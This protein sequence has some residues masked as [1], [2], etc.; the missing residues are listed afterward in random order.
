MIRKQ[1]DLS[2]ICGS[3]LWDVR[4]LMNSVNE[5]SDEDFVKNYFD[6]S[7]DVLGIIMHDSYN[8]KAQLISFIDENCLMNGTPKGISNLRS[9]ITSDGF[10][11]IHSDLFKE[12]LVYP[13]FGKKDIP[14]SITKEI[15][16]SIVVALNKVPVLGERLLIDVLEQK[17]SYISLDGGKSSF[18]ENAKLRTGIA[19]CLSKA[20]KS[21]SIL[22]CS[23][24]FLGIKDFK[25]RKEF[26]V[27]PR[28]LCASSFYVDI[29]R[30]NFLEDYYA[31]TGLS[32]ANTIFSGGRH[33]HLFV[34]DTEEIRNKT[35]EYVRAFNTWL[36]K[37]YG[38]EMYVSY[39]FS[40]AGPLDIKSISKE[41]NENRYRNYYSEI[42]SQRQIME[43]SKYSAKDIISLKYTYSEEGR[44]YTK[45]KNESISNLLL[46]DYD[47]NKLLKVFEHPV[48]RSVEIGPRRYLSF[49]NVFDSAPIRCYWRKNGGSPQNVLEQESVG[50]LCGIWYG[51][52]PAALSEDQN[53]AFEG[54]DSAILRLD[55]DNFRSEMFGDSEEDELNMSFAR[56]MEQ[57][58][59]LGLFLRK[60]IYVL[61]DQFV[62]SARDES[63]SKW[64]WII[65]EGADDAFVA[66]DYNSVLRFSELL[67]CHYYRYSGNKMSFSGGICRYDPH[68]DSFA[69][70]AA[71]AQHLMD[72]A[73]NAA[74]KN[75]V[76]IEDTEHCVKW[77]RIA[78]DVQNLKNCF[79]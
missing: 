13:A 73:K 62:K 17:C 72:Y 38:T 45:Q 39:G 49:V 5:R 27:S 55:I 20:G 26:C 35:E 79:S 64:L 53:I 40:K 77:E 34:P 66:G 12:E 46:Q 2:L 29:M 24:D 32:Y 76:A 68:N 48:D 47:N 67:I 65:H 28:T 60:D 51:G 59:H 22:I 18:F 21:G 31:H 30:E 37:N 52:I 14:I 43:A 4:T 69:T 42:V 63:K 74:G 8:Q 16:E 23:F 19:L 11:G 6:I 41:E 15:L 1:K 44:L 25:F 71:F 33:L 61:A 56:K 9:P 70:C 50:E 3:L 7:D 54:N 58:K 10:Y 78:G 57:S 36:V 75:S